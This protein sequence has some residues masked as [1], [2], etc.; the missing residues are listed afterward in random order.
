MT[1]D[2]PDRSDDSS[3]DRSDRESGILG[4]LRRFLET[5]QEMEQQ[6]ES[7]RRGRVSSDRG[8]ADYSIHIGHARHDEMGERTPHPEVSPDSPTSI[9]ETDEGFIVHLDLPEAEGHTVVTGD[10]GRT[11]VVGTDDG[12]DDTV[13]TRVDMPR[14]G[15]TVVAGAY[16]NGVLELHLEA[17]EDQTHE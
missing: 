15:L 10:E 14:R 11:L 4:S 3:E 1:N 12:T 13:F 6:G 8:V 9:R 16:R 7:T 2:T 17:E 5:L